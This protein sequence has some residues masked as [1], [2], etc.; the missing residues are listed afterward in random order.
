MNL[1]LHILS[2]GT[3]AGIFQFLFDVN[4]NELHAM[5]EKNHRERLN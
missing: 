4:Q 3:K 5:L 1:L 2:S